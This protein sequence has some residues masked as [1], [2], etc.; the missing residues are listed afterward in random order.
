MLHFALREENETILRK[1]IISL[2]VVGLLIGI[3]E[4]ETVIATKP[5][6]QS[7]ENPGERPSVL[8]L[9]GV[10]LSEALE[11]HTD[12]TE[13]YRENTP[14]VCYGNEPVSATLAEIQPD[15]NFGSH[16]SSAKEAILGYSAED[17]L[18]TMIDSPD[19]IHVVNISRQQPEKYTAEEK[20]M[21]AF[22]VFA[23]ARGECF[24]GMV[25]VAQVVINRYESGR[26]GN[27]IRSVVYSRD[28]FAVS[29]RYND[30]C[31]AAVEYAIESSPYPNTMY[32]FQKS[33]RKNW[34]GVYYGR[35][36][37]HS[38]YCGKA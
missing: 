20:E 29:K 25:A 13:A 24:E 23:E 7:T 6:S 18:E 2:V 9:T 4:V 3:C 30:V 31:M 27:T 36:G 17:D 19:F 16:I 5:I 10:T 26:F 38:F 33:K 8:G 14:A 12:E 28:Q 34:Y 15:N 35:I 11:K 21:V 1:A 22:V 37:S 32:Y